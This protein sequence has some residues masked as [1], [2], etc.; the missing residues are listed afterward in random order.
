MIADLSGIGSIAALATAV[1]GGVM[2]FIQRKAAKTDQPGSKVA[3][4]KQQDEKAIADGTAGERLDSQLDR[5][6]KP[7][8]D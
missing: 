8:G 3:K 2:W 7:K 4:E 5:L 1:L 6:S